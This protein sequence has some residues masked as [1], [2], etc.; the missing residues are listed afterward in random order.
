MA[1]ETH[2]R[3]KTEE[4]EALARRLQ[5]QWISEDSA[6]GGQGGDN[7]MGGVQVNYCI[8]I[9]ISCSTLVIQEFA[10]VFVLLCVR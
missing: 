8:Y 9:L 3:A 6:G 7:D 1:P 2:R 10:L 4:D 5:A